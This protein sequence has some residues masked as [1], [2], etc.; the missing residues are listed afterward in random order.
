[1]TRK[2]LLLLPMLSCLLAS[3][4]LGQTAAQKP[5][6]QKPAAQKPA[7]VTPAPM[8]P[9]A[10]PAPVSHF[11]NGAW[12]DRGYLSANVVWQT[13]TPSFTQTAVVD[14]LRGA[15]LRHHRIPG[16]E[17]DRRGHGRRMAHLAEPGDR[18]RPVGRE[19]VFD[20]RRGRIDA[21]SALRE[22]ADDAV[23][24]IRGEPQRDGD[25]CPGELDDGA[26]AEDGADG[27]RQGR[28]S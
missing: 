18:R 14:L 28:R 24:W 21:Q 13:A 20:D 19:P 5:A 15:G 11:K 4:A 25:Q 3:A 1:M 17:R 7:P 27:V 6:A 12:L 22:A 8:K 10:K 23:G 9:A 2:P 26:P 16:R